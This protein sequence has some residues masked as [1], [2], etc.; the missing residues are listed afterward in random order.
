MGDDN[1]HDKNIWIYTVQPY[2]DAIND[3]DWL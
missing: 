3:P 2:I 1:F